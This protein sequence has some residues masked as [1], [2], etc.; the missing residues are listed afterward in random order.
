MALS[1][2]RD[3]VR[4]EHGATIL[5]EGGGVRFGSG[6][7]RAL[8]IECEGECLLWDESTH[9]VTGIGVRALRQAGNELVFGSPVDLEYWVDKGDGILFA[10]GTPQP[11]AV[12]GFE[13]APW[14]PLAEDGWRTNN[15]SRAAF[16]RRV[17]A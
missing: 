12:R 10:R 16:R 7:L 15:V 2:Q 1:P 3:Q 14:V 13:L 4:N 17:E 6:V 8:G 9:R 5:P 11:E